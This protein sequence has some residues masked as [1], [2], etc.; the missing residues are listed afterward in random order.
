MKKSGRLGK[1]GLKPIDNPY[2]MGINPSDGN[3]PFKRIDGQKVTFYVNKGWEDK[4]PL[5][6]YARIVSPGTYKAEGTII[7]GVASRNIVNIGK[8]D[9]VIVE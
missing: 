3:T 5:V 6:Y 1:S 8:Q 4:K 9:A 2:N 7:Q